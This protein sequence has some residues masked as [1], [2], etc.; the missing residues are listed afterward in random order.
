V[1]RKESGNA[2]LLLN[3]LEQCCGGD[4]EFRTYE[5]CVYRRYFFAPQH[6]QLLMRSAGEAHM[7]LL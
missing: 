4:A 2:K 1:T 6:K 5:F 3:G 7:R